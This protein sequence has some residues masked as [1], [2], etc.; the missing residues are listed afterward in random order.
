M[1]KTY[2][3]SH[4][5]IKLARLIEAAKHDIKK[6]MKRER[7]KALPKGADYWGF[8]CKYGLDENTAK[9]IH[10]GEVNKCIDEAERQGLASFY[11]EVHSKPIVSDKLSA[12]KH[13]DDNE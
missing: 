1:K 2:Q 10:A 11:I 9:T 5:K 12:G 13:F 7:R 3:L 4:P 8:D 6:Y